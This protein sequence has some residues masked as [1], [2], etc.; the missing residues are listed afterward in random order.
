MKT[1]LLIPS[2]FIAVIC[3]TVSTTHAKIWRVNNRTDIQVQADFTTA[4]AAHDGASA[5]DTIFFEPS[6]DSY[7]SLS[8]KKKLVVIGTG[9]FLDKNPETQWAMWPSTLSSV[10]LTRLSSS[11]SEYSQ[12]MGI[13]CGSISIKVPN[14]NISRNKCSISLYNNPFYDTISNIHIFQNYCSSFYNYSNVAHD[15]YINN[16]IFTG[17]VQASDVTNSCLINNVCINSAIN[18]DYFSV[19]NNI[20]IDGTFE[21]LNNIYSY[22]IA[23]NSAFGNQFGNQENINP[24]TLFLCFYDCPS[25]FSPDAR[26]QLTEG[27]PAIGAGADGMDCGAFGGLNP[28]VLS[29]M[30]PV[31]AIYFFMLGASNNQI[32]VNLKLKSHN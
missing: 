16:N 13:T 15:I 4:Q 10:E 25:G 11:T 32:N 27:S 9:Y 8:I 19:Q 20:M 7:G 6:P 26:Y 31:P 18:V 28:Y 14:I 5:G 22:N 17:L 12:I 21:P 30:P 24:E 23:N 29:G 2:L 1:S 3:L